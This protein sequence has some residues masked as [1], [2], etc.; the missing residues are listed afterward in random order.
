MSLHR[1]REKRDFRAT[2]E[3][4]GR[5]TQH[6]GRLHFVVQK[7]H[8]RRL[9]YD[10]RLELDGALKSW[11]VPKGPSLDP[12]DKRMA[13]HVEDHPLDYADFEG[14]IPPGQYGAGEV[15]VWD[16]GEWEPEGDAREGL[17]Q[18][19]LKFHLH[20][21]KLEGGWA[22]VRMHGRE[23][24]KQEPWLL[25]KERDEHARAANEYSVVD[26]QPDSVLSKPKLPAGAK[27]AALPKALSP[28]LAT[29]VGEAPRDDGQWLYEIKFDGYRV[30]ARIDG[31]EVH[32]F[33]RNGNDWT[34]KLESL[35][36]EV[37]TLQ[38]ESAWLDGEIV[39]L[40]KHGAPDF[41]ALQN[42]FDR[43]AV[44]QVQ[45]FVF[46]LPYYA[47]HD[48]RAVPLEQRR[49]LL[50]TLMQ[51]AHSP[52]LRFSE[53]FEAPADELL[54]K[55]CHMRLEGVIGKRRDAPYVSRRTTSWIKLKCTQRQEFVIGGYTD[56]QGSR[57]GIGAL[58]LGIHD[59]SGQLRYA[60][61]VGTG[62]DTDTLKMLKQRLAPLKATQC[63]FQEPP[64][65]ARGHWVKPQLVAE[66]SFGE[67]TPD[68]RVRH[69]VFH[70]LREDKPARSITRETAA[71][72]P[73]LPEGLHISHPERVID[74]TT[75][76]TKL[77]LVN[78][79]LRVAKR[80]LPHLAGRPVAVLRAPSGVDGQ[81]F[82]QKHGE[83]LK[84]PALTHLDPALDPG[85]PAMMQIDSFEALVGAAQMNVVEFHTWNALSKRIEQ[86]DRMTFDLDTG[87]GVS[88][89]QMREAAQLVHALLDELGLANFLKTSG[90]KG[91]HV[92]VPLTPRA[93][94]DTVRDFSR[95]VVQHLA[96]V[97]PDRFVAKS[98][99]SNRV[100]KIFVDYLRNGRGATTVAAFSA[101]ARAGLGVSIPCAW[102]ELPTLTA[103]DQWNIANA[104]ERLDSG[105][106]PWADY[107]K[108]KQTL[109]GAIKKLGK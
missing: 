42:A 44:E 64:R 65:E 71:A 81:H 32:L 13:V 16:R 35:A 54:N 97:L 84:I 34:T 17:R 4:K 73:A 50:G 93:D 98:G 87:E 7:H 22:L 91:L 49:A 74:K 89:A 101:R 59:A 100:G 67:W 107:A 104:H 20:G 106:D 15:I 108:T 1:Y 86:P 56:P 37:A 51:R 61:R 31:D 80:M 6:R 26:A 9:H 63:P 85:H 29:L 8:A 43:A 83:S 70:G 38:L 68:A 46:D 105:E 103:G 77:D 11:A 48:L 36:G 94:W 92:V 40:D 90:G 82:F 55:A 60:G 47:G 62:F 5:T 102:D 33:T 109:S 41:N 24:E 25:I 58:L 57:S 66:V 45:F 21:D 95:A 19:H 39:L 52:R 96:D 72:A 53:A 2:P 69:S 30:L 88:W 14:T 10:F 99:A 79:Y 18:G 3:P 27:R 28:Q 75:G 78:H 76:F 12:A 23:R